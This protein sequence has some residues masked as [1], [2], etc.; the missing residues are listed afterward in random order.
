MND[1][2]EYFLDTTSFQEN[3]P[4]GSLEA[5]LQHVDRL[6]NLPLLTTSNMV[7]LLSLSEKDKHHTRVW[8]ALNDWLEYDTKYEALCSDNHDREFGRLPLKQISGPNPA[9]PIPER[10][11]IFDAYLKENHRDCCDRSEIKMGILDQTSYTS[12]DNEWD[13]SINSI[14]SLECYVEASKKSF[15]SIMI[16]LKVVQELV[17]KSK[18]ECAIQSKRTSRESKLANVI[19]QSATLST[20]R[21]LTLRT[22]IRRK[23]EIDSTKMTID[24]ANNQINRASSMLQDMQNRTKYLG[25][26]LSMINNTKSRELKSLMLF[27]K[28]LKL[29]TIGYSAKERFILK[30]TQREP[31]LPAEIWYNIIEKVIPNT[32]NTEVN[33]KPDPALKRWM[34]SKTL[35][36]TAVLVY[37]TKTMFWCTPDTF[38][39][40]S[41]FQNIRNITINL[42]SSQWNT[43]A[44]VSNCICDLPRTTAS[45]E[46]YVLQQRLKECSSLLRLRFITPPCSKR[47]GGPT[48]LRW[49]SLSKTAL[50]DLQEWKGSCGCCIF[51]KKSNKCSSHISVPVDKV[52]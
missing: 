40:F 14:R 10:E 13:F 34:I 18:K 42:R 43:H 35:F 29:L 19:L 38:M 27:V 33:G 6:E 25:D 26:T 24:K 39:K 7:T 28:R 31:Y 2:Q 8:A 21:R 12:M 49:V 46:T 22:S 51:S 3:Q 1:I 41:T 36:Q 4:K 16:A 52:V 44:I 5:F 47:T 11:Y 30:K 23:H 48:T 17:H 32:N 15:V 9:P 45:V 50:L 20:Q 37:Y